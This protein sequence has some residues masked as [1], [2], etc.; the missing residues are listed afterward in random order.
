MSRKINLTITTMIISQ[1]IQPIPIPKNPSF[2]LLFFFFLSNYYYSAKTLPNKPV[3]DTSIT[4]IIAKNQVNFFKGLTIRH[5][6]HS[7]IKIVMAIPNSRCVSAS[8]L[9]AAGIPVVKTG[10]TVNTSESV[11]RNNLNLL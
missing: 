9:Y 5:K 11:Y 6:Y 7:Q 4:V 3:M 10:C 1:T 8:L 2:I